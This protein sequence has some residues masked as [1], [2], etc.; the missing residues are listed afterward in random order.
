MNRRKKKIRFSKLSKI[1]LIFIPIL[2]A[3]SVYLFFRTGFFT[4]KEIEVK[5]DNVICTDKN[6][7]INKS[8]YGFNFF[9]LDKQKIENTLKD[10]FICIKSINLGRSFPNKII[11]DVNSRKPSAILITIL[12]QQASPA[13]LIK[14]NLATSSAEPIKDSFLVDDEGIVFSKNGITEL[15]IPKIYSYDSEIIVGQ[16]IGDIIKNALKILDKVKSLGLKINQSWIADGL[17]ILQAENQESGN[18]TKI[19]FQLDSKTSLMSDKQLDIQIASLQLILA[20]AKINRRTVPAEVGMDS[21]NL[22]FI[23][24]RFD[25]PIIKLA[26]KK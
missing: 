14:N 16:K 8:F 11:I 13:A 24:L 3:L 10:K 5:G 21:G 26:P 4:V 19:I 1:T 2:I 9:F 15:S 20:E 23:D 7:L 18:M 12:N 6:Q 25:K 22:E 17:Y